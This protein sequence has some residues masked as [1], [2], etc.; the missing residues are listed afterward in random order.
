VELTRLL[1]NPRR[2]WSCLLFAA[3][4]LTGCGIGKL[5]SADKKRRGG[6]GNRAKW[7]AI[8]KVENGTG[9]ASPLGGSGADAAARRAAADGQ[10][11]PTKM[12]GR[13]AKS[14]SGDFFVPCSD[15]IRYVVQGTSEARA[16]MR[17]RLRFTVKILKT[18]LY[19]VFT[20]VYLVPKPAAARAPGATP[21]ETKGFTPTAGLKGTTTTPASLARKAIF[22]SKVDTM[23]STIPT[24]CRPPITRRSAGW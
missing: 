2:V 10:P 16:L 5:D 9:D 11:A 23:T 13:Y 8:S 15:T 14:D 12:R 3:F 17:E 19:A 4:A 22:V 21:L 7:Q 1:S 6:S 20:G 24:A 18:P